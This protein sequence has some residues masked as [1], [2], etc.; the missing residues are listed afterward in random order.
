MAI[1]EDDVDTLRE[2]FGLNDGENTEKFVERRFAA[3]ISVSGFAINKSFETEL[4]VDDDA[5][6]VFYRDSN[7]SYV[8][9][10]SGDFLIIFDDLVEVVA[11]NNKEN[12]IYQAALTSYEFEENEFTM[13]PGEVD[14]RAA[15]NLYTVKEEE[16]KPVRR[17]GFKP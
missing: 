10:H 2:S 13:M 17:Q 15:D 8:V 9:S 7:A 11:E 4:A 14:M 6:V 16:I 12:A 3:D 1:I 5:H